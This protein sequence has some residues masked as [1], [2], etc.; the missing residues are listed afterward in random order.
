MYVALGAL[1]LSTYVL[2]MCAV[3]CGK[4][5]SRFIW[6]GLYPFRRFWVF[7]MIVMVVSFFVLVEDTPY[8][9]WFLISAATWAPLLWVDSLV[10]WRL[11]WL[12]VWSTAAATL[13]I[14]AEN[15]NRGWYTAAAGWLAFHHVV[16]DG[17]VWLPQYVDACEDEQDARQK[18]FQFERVLF[19]E[20]G[21]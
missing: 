19:K 18:P 6:G 7:S 21:P 3:Y 13:F 8:W 5:E 9:W 2:L 14:L 12:S 17:I 1:V 20:D 15:W 4:I 16:L 10:Q 11:S